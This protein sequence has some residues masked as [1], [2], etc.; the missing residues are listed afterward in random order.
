MTTKKGVLMKTKSKIKSQT[1]ILKM[2]RKR[3]IFVGKAYGSPKGARGY[4]RRKAND[5]R[6][7]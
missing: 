2:V 4:S 3:T 7:W 5:S 1:E 6:E